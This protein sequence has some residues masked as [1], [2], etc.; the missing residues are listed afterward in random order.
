MLG[1]TS[2][3]VSPEASPGERDTFGGVKSGQEDGDLRRE[4]E[5]EQAHLDEPFKLRRDGG[6]RLG[7]GLI[8]NANANDGRGGMEAARSGSRRPRAGFGPLDGAAAFGQ[9]DQRE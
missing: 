6:S 3:C 8:T 1:P 7:A 9:I 2:S 4:L 5:D